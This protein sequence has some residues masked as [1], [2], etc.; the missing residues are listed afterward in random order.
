LYFTSNTDANYPDGAM[1][2]LVQAWVG[3]SW[4]LDTALRGGTRGGPKGPISSC[5]MILL[6]GWH[7]FY[8]KY[9]CQLSRW[10]HG[11]IGSGLCGSILAFRYGP[12]SWYPRGSQ[13]YY[14]KLSNTLVAWLACILHQI[15]M[16]TIPMEPWN[17]W[18]RPGWVDP[19]I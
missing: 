11:T 5:Q 6:R 13:R 19:G 2:P 18:F 4:H 10:S 9:R 7:A 15:Q 1:E 8:I 17:H 12:W 16:P 14:L 3:R